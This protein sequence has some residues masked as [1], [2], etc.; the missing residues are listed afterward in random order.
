MVDRRQ[1]LGPRAVVLG[2][3]QALRRLLTPLAEDADVGVP[4]AVDRLELVAD[5]E[6]VLRGAA[7]QEVDQLALERVRVLELVDHDRAEAQLLGLADPLVVARAGRAR[8]AGDPRSR[9]PTRAPS[10]PR[11]RPRRGRAAPAAGRGRAPRRARARPARRRLRASSKLAARGPARAERARGRSASPAATAGRARPGGGDVVRGR[12]RV[13]EQALRRLAQLAPSCARGRRGSPSSSTSGRP[14]E[15]SVVVDA[16]QH[17]AQLDGSRRWRAGA[18]RSS[19]RRTRRT[20]RARAR[21]PRRAA[22]RRAR[23]RARGSAGRSRPRTGARAAAARRSRGWSR[24]RRRRA[25]VRGRA[26]RASTSAARMRERS[27]AAALRVYVMTSTESTSSPSSQTART[28]R[29]TST[30][31]LPVPAP[32]ETNTSPRASTAAM[33]AARSCA[34]PPGTSSRGRTTPGTRRPSGRGATSP[35]RIRCARTRGAR[36]R[37]VS[38]CAQNGSSSR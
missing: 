25:R 10:R 8:G 23:R 27:S 24:S 32:A 2:Q 9:A 34:A 17:P 4:E 31:V 1:H 30:V 19:D 35:A 33:L 28:N 22:P 36:S 38:T 3:R 7:G 12:L 18:S 21:T 26:G 5:V 11:T 29:S 20:R 13:V 15:R 14:A 16:G 6:D 37:A